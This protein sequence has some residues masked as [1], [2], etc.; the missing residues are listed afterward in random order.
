MASVGE[1]RDSVCDD[2]TSEFPLQIRMPCRLQ[3]L[4]VMGMHNPFFE[5]LDNIKV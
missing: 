2:Q 1:V 5:K 3:G 4:S